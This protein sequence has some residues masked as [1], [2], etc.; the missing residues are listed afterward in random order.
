MC[1]EISLSLKIPFL[2]WLPLRIFTPIEQNIKTYSIH[3]QEHILPC[4]YKGEK[5]VVRS[6]SPEY[7]NDFN[8]KANPHVYRIRQRQPGTLSQSV[9]LTEAS[10]VH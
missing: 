2:V 9:K 7:S 3:I 8:Y 10:L 1:I 5:K 4:F 6:L